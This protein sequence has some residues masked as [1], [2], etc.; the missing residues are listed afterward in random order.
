MKADDD[1]GEGGEWM[2]VDPDPDPDALDVMRALHEREHVAGRLPEPDEV[3]VEWQL[4]EDEVEAW[5]AANGTGGLAP[6]GGAPASRLQVID[7]HLTE[8][9]T[10]TQQLE[11][12]TA[13]RARLIADAHR[14][15]ATL[16]EDRAAERVERELRVDSPR[17]RAEL[18]RRS[19]T[20]EIACA[21][22]ASESTVARWLTEAEVLTGQLP[23]TLSAAL[24]GRI[25]YRH[26]STLADEAETLPPSVRAAF[27]Q[28]ALPV[29]ET[30]TVAQFTR[31]ARRLRERMHPDSIEA[32]NRDAA[33]SRHVRISPDRDGMAWLSAYLPSAKAAVVDA[34]LTDCAGQL[35]T[36]NTETRTM[37]QLRADV[38]TDLL[39]NPGFTTDP[40]TD[41]AAIGSTVD[42]VVAGSTACGAGRGGNAGHDGPAGSLWD[43]GA[44][45][46]TGPGSA[47]CRSAGAPR[48]HRRGI[49]PSVSVTVPVLSMLGRGDEPALLDGYGPI[50]I[51]Q[52]N[53][54]AG[55]ASSW[56]RLLT[57]PET[58]AILSVGRDRYTVPPDLRQWL[59]VRDGTCRF[60]GC[61]RSAVAC[62][63]DHTI[64]W[65]GTGKTEH[66]N[67]AHTCAGHH[68]LK[69]ETDWRVTQ[70]DTGVLTWTSPTG[71]TYTTA[72][73]NDL[74]A[75]VPI[76]V[77]HA[78]QH[79]EAPF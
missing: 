28:A 66:C 31:R 32:R 42:P 47:A 2:L 46:S 76:P 71:R 63:I 54:L 51:D 10:L 20:A 56:L 18:A 4:F 53:E 35:A 58:G 39:L 36:A 74:P 61:T 78:E 7:L 60:P 73:G 79:E 11:R 12:V 48:R 24:A 13:R 5:R 37:S 67:L 19:I 68:H 25:S 9:A 49:R 41:P 72:P 30:S 26:A 15:A 55:V 70:N 27:E 33:E 45:G 75:P 57:H 8:I 14:E 59:R 29:A 50:P 77:A 38:F 3:D 65:D 69:H 62:E 22:R 16:A 52:A 44:A 64:D 34:S 17:R 6:D 23:R 43:V 40:A 1:A 21:V